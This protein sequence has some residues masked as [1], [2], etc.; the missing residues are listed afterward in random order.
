VVLQDEQARLT[1][2]LEAQERDMAY[3]SKSATE[4]LA[5]LKQQHEEK[6]V[7]LEASVDK[8][9]RAAKLAEEVTPL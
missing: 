7:R 3:Q 4:T 1:E 8:A 9:T 5:D 2:R 6:R